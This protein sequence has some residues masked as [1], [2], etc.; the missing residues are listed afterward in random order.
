MKIT[1]IPLFFFLLTL[2]HPII[3]CQGFPRLHFPVESEG[4]PLAYGFAGGLNCPQFLNADLNQ[5]GVQDLV[6]FDRTGFQLL[7]FIYNDGHYLFSPEYKKNFP[8]TLQHWVLLRDYNGDGAMDIFSYSDNAAID[9]IIVYQGFYQSGNLQFKRVRFNERV[10]D[11]L[12]ASIPGS[13]R[14]QIYVSRIDYPEVQDI[15]CD[16][17]MDILTFNVAGGVVEYYRNLSKERGHGLDSLVFILHDNCWGD[18]FESGL[19]NSVDLSP[20]K[21]QCFS[22]LAEDPPISVRHSGSTILAFDPDLD[23]DMDLA[24]GDISF[25]Q[26]N[27]LHNGGNCTAAWMNAQDPSFPNY[28]LPIDIPV[29]PATFLVDVDHD[30]LKDLLVAPN[31]IFNSEPSNVGWLYQAN[32]ENNRINYSFRQS[33]FIVGEMVDLGAGANPW[34][35][36]INADGLLDIVTGNFYIDEL[37]GNASLHYF[38]NIGTASDP[39]FQW[40]EKD[41][42]GLQAI[43]ASFTSELAPCFGDL[44]GDEDEDLLVGELNGKLFFFENTAGIGNPMQFGPAQYGFHN[45]DVGLSSVPCIADLNADGLPDLLIGEQNGN[46]N[47]FL[48]IGTKQHPKFEPDPEKSPN[49]FFFA[50]IDTRTPGNS[51]GYSSPFFFRQQG[52]PFLITGSN[53]SNLE[54]Y[55]I[56]ENNLQENFK[57]VKE[58]LGNI[59]VGFRTRP[60][61]ADINSD[62]WLDILVGNTRGGFEW[63]QSDMAST[64]TDVEGLRPQALKVF[65]NPTTGFLVVEIPPMLRQADLHIRLVNLWGQEVNI[66][67][68]GAPER[69]VLQLTGLPQGVY[70]LE[71]RTVRGE[72]YFN[73]ICIMGN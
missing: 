61:L 23:G 16:G 70:L 54:L 60:V 15:D 38:E 72:S 26:V 14:S 7:P 28:N 25:N 47:L 68:M 29:F 45:I 35:V 52:V 40:K 64:I 10:K 27:V 34:L 63:F 13:G 12:F 51:A 9:G 2:P 46:I 44:D 71:V 73:K 49:F 69:Q 37:G 50:N 33:D 32:Q 8:A 48:N 19:T 43:A 66:P 39:S 30:G 31:S 18:F 58:N 57:G 53:V 42:L 21:G 36:D 5:D 62:G 59:N 41:F 6:I 17:D 11:L 22:R 1:I 4:S 3:Y 56:N 65:P 55:E 67:S 20:V 24:L